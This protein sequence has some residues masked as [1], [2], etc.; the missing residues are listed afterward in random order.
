MNFSIED[1]LD[2]TDSQ[3]LYQLNAYVRYVLFSKKS[4]ECRYR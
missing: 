2:I 4:R 3:K 1:M